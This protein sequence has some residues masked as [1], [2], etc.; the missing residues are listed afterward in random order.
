MRCANRKWDQTKKRRGSSLEVEARE[1][2]LGTGEAADWPA[3]WLG[4]R[5]G[6]ASADVG[7]GIWLD[8]QGLNSIGACAVTT[9]GSC[10][11]FYGFDSVCM[12]L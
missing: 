12:I 11:G 10:D 1:N 9:W 2:V 4:K 8:G 7:P 5:R 6:R 3:G